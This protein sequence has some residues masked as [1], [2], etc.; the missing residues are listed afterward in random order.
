M[1]YCAGGD[2]SSAIKARKRLKESTCKIFLQQ[3]SLALQYLRANNV[4]HMDLKPQ[5]LL[6]ASRS[7]PTLKLT[8]FPHLY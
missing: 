4:S 6:L 7:N 5:N 8:G 3:L 1:E 2:L